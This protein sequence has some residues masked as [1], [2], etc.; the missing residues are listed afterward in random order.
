MN[1]EPLSKLEDISIDYAIMEK[2]K[3]VVTIPYLSK[4]SDMGDWDAVWAEVNRDQSGTALS[5]TAH[6]I[7][8]SNTLLA[9]IC[10]S[11]NCWTRFKQYYRNCD[12]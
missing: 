12:A 1:P 4:W 6:A 2:A 9:R 11:A 8:C 5:K 3:N 7:D 10:R